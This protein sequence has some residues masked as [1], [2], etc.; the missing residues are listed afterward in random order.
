MAFYNINRQEMDEFLTGQG[1]QQMTLPGTVELVYGKIVH[2]NGHRLSLRVYT[3]INPTGESREKGSDAIRVQL[4]WMFDGKPTPVGKAQK[5]LRVTTW[6][7][8]MQAAIDSHAEADN[9]ATCPAC[10]SPMVIRHR[11]SDNAEFWGCSTWIKTKCGGR[12]NK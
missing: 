9:F 4:Y 11:G 5:C 8:N 6:R 1:F 2:H 3:A 7:K 10:G 12:P